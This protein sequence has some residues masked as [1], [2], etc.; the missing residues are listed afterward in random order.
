MNG[1]K[2]GELFCSQEKGKVITGV[3]VNVKADQLKGKIPGVMLVVWCD[4]DRVACKKE[5]V[6]NCH[7]LVKV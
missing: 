6:P 1:G 5:K 7:T 4:T 2:T 3:A